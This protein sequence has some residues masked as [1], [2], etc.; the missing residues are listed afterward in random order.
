MYSQFLALIGVV[1]KYRFLSL[2]C[3][4]R[5]EIYY[6][7]INL[8]FYQAISIRQLLLSAISTLSVGLIKGEIYEC[9]ENYRFAY[10]FIRSAGTKAQA[11]NL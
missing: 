4:C 3:N 2:I 1:A 10:E 5:V 7:I 8:Y 6:K 11:Y 9:L